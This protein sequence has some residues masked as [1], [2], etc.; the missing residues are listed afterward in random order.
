MPPLKLA[1]GDLMTADF[2]LRHRRAL[3][4][5]EPQ[6]RIEVGR[7]RPMIADLIASLYNDQANVEQR[8]VS[9]PLADQDRQKAR[10]RMEECRRLL[11]RHIDNWGDPGVSDEEYV[12]TA[13]ALGRMRDEFG[14]DARWHAELAADI[15]CWVATRVLRDAWPKLPFADRKACDR[16]VDS[17]SALVRVAVMDV[18]IAGAVQTETNLD[19]R[20][21]SVWGVTDNFEA[22]VGAVVAGLTEATKDLETVARTM[23]VTAE[24][25][26]ERSTMVAVA[27]EQA[28]A[29]V[30]IV[31]A[32]TEEMGKSVSEIAH[33]VNH[34]TQIAS[35]AVANAQSA[36]ETIE[37]MAESAERIGRIVELISEIAGQTNL[38][39]L[40]ATIESARAGEAGRGFAVVAS[41]VKTLATQTAKATQEI[42]AQI[43]AMQAISREA[44]RALAEVTATIDEMNAVSMAINAAVEEQAAATQEIAR[45]T[46]EAATGAGDVSRAISEVQQGAQET[47]AASS[48]VLA[49]SQ[50]LDG[51]AQTLHAA[52]SR[53]LQMLRAA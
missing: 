13:R 15:V 51:R 40:N 39:A 20:L 21:K 37:H 8:E 9:G 50:E 34:S 33:Q 10:E 19:A 43:R 29:N 4:K 31:A 24:H 2:D 44:A 26:G 45:N 12:R 14:M 18:E 3:L 38:L 46:H 28:T 49:A 41:E 1:P 25:A 42:G 5:V 53:F 35:K 22:D 52:V 16:A 32:S 47:G 48:R 23:A 36:N 30:S 6:T 11:E 27:A 17:I 7:L